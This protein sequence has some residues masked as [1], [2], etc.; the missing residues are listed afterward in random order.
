MAV[1]KQGFR[2][3]SNR[4]KLTRPGRGG[5][6][7]NSRR[8]QRAPRKLTIPWQGM[9]SFM[10][11]AAVV[12]CVALFVLGIS[13]S[14]VYAYRYFTTNSYFALKILE[15]EGN[16]RLSSKE[17]LEITDLQN[18]ANILKL[19]LPSVEEL[20]GRNPW[21]EEVSV[22]RVLPGK[23]VIGVRE[24]APVF[25]LLH[26]GSLHYA[27]AWGRLIAPVVPGQLASLPA[28][29]VEP[30]AEEATAALPDLVKSLEDSQ[31]P[32]K[33]AS[34]SLVRL[35]AARGVEVYLENSRLKLTIGLEDWLPNL[36]RLSK[37]LPDLGRRGEL[38]QVREIKAQGA[39]GWVEKAPSPLRQS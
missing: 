16:S 38:G 33:M 9:G 3:E 10:V 19:S 27:D 21:V 32:V 30:G 39:D 7:K 20:V 24:K 17:I 26:N 28:L 13:F 6:G 29:E 31:L 18:G 5:P 37:T 22:Q 23:L 2:R 25:W 34:V 36:D 12:S 11:S 15:I 4:I 35:S 14:L 8:E 1:K